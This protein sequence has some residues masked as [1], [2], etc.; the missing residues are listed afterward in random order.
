MTYLYKEILGHH[1][2]RKVLC[3]VWH[4]IIMKKILGNAGSLSLPVTPDSH[5]TV[6][7][8]ISSVGDI[9]G[10]M[11]LNSCN[12]SPTLFH[13]V[14]DMV[15]VI[16]LNQT[17]YTAHAADDSALLTVVNVIASDDMASDLFL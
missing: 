5:G 10:C 14:V 12:F 3:V 2:S 6:M 13:H 1:A 7:D 16:I 9:N 8:V 17:E 15:D 4:L 11:H